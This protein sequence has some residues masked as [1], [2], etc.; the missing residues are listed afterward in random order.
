MA[1]NSQVTG[2]ITTFYDSITAQSDPEESGHGRQVARFSEEIAQLLRLPEEQ[3][4]LLRVAAHL[5]DVGK[6]TLP[7]AVINKP[8]AFSMPE[9]F[10]MQ[11][12]PHIG[13]E[14]LQPFQLGNLIMD[15][16]LHHHE[17]Y[18]GRGYPHGLEGE[19]VSLPAAIVHVAD[20]YDAL[21]SARP[22]RPAPFSRIEAM[23]VILSERGAY[24]PAV[25]KAFEKVARL[26]KYE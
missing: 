14:M 5:H 20:V 17:R 13:W 26:T 1:K 2:T 22:Y 24:H 16:V 18:D 9:R 10:M 19:G 8:G 15:V 6:V 4:T 25:L 7:D 11:Q 23:Q 21:T 12:H 3:I